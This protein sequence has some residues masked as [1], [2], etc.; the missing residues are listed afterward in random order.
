VFLV[1]SPV[2]DEGSTAGRRGKLTWNELAT[3]ASVN[4]LRNCGAKWPLRIK[5]REARGPRL[6]SG[7]LIG[8]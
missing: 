5:P 1:T 6:C 4:S 2:R 8:F 7:A 3:E